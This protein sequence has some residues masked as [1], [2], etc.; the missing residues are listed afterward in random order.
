[1]KA[2]I[3][4][5][6]ILLV[7]LL[8]SG[9]ML[10]V[11]QMY[12]LPKRSETYKDLQ[13]AID[14]AMNDLDY[15][16]P[17]SG[18]NQQTVQLADLDGD[19]R[20]E[21]LLFAKSTQEDKPLRILVFQKADGKFVNTDIVECNGYAFDQVEYV[22]MNGD[23]GLELL[24][25]RQL[26]DQLIRSVSVYT[27]SNNE[28]TQLVT[29]SYSKF[30]TADLNTDGLSEMFVLRP[31]QTDTDNGVAE[32]YK[33]NG[34]SIER[35]NEV[36]MSQPVDKLKRVL[37]GKIDGE[38]P[39]V[40]TASAVG[41][42]ALITDIYLLKDDLLVNIGLSDDSDT[43]IQTLRNF[44]IYADDI[45]GDTVV[46]LPRL[47][48]MAETVG[49]SSNQLICWYAMTA[50]G[51]E[52][53]KM[54][55]YHNFVGGWYMQLGRKWAERVK[56]VTGSNE[57]TFSVWNEEGTKCERVFTVYALSG[58]SRET[59]AAEEGYIELYKTDTVVYVAVLEAC[60]G[61][62]DLNAQTIKNNFRLIQ[63]DW[64]TGET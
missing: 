2:G 5:I 48:T 10:T 13:T 60:A 44:Y 20:N 15:C 42:S 6:P 31:G 45:D 53:I 3:K 14:G 28:L 1:M 64:K 52:I 35:Y 34:D 43:S 39:A 41:E 16:A 24:V 37:V 11:D 56:V 27:F 23:G 19:G 59:Q 26:S 4:F 61:E 22:D 32:L 57:C 47:I 54:Y 62:Y 58:Q 50:D 17:L 7:A 30:L 55:T 25:G 63:Q 29:V 8:L 21:Y 40:Y 9:C 46:E 38:I 51:G 12:C 36:T 49:T 33:M 18:E